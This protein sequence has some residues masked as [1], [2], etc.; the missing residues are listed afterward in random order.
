[1]K[2]MRVEVMIIDFDEVGA[3]GIKS[4]LESASY[5]NYCLSPKVIK[6]EERDIGEWR[7][8]HPLNIRTTSIQA[9]QD[10]FKNP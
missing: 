10:L 4:V 6:V 2:V 5:P 9:Y 7:D 8:D 1:M 3:N